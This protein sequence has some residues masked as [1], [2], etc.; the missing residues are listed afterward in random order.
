MQ[1]VCSC[2]WLCY[3][4]FLIQFLK[5]CNPNY[6]ISNK[7]TSQLNWC[8]RTLL[9]IYEFDVHIGCDEQHYFPILLYKPCSCIRQKVYMYID[10]VFYQILFSDFT[11]LYDNL[12]NKNFILFM[13]LFI[14]LFVSQLY[15]QDVF[16][17]ILGFNQLILHQL[18]YS[19]SENKIIIIKG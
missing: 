1:N 8:Q 6:P 15:N 12:F 3:H 14:Y 11:V 4:Q 2:S 10:T 7:A 17:I 5:V 19:P 9:L 16:I 13:Y 18:L